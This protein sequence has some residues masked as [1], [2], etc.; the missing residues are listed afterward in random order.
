M[1]DQRPHQ[2]SDVRGPDFAACTP[3]QRESVL[4]GLAHRRSAVHAELLRAIAAADRAEDYKA[5]GMWSMADW[6]TYRYALPAPVARQWVKAAHALED[7]PLLRA[8][9]AA[10]NVSFDQ[11]TQALS[12]AKPDDD[13]TLAELLPTLGFAEVEAMAKRRRRLRRGDADDA[14]RQTHLR[15][16][17]DR[18][19]LGSRV[20]GFLPTEDAAVI[21]E[22]LDRRTEAAGPDPETGIWG[23]YDQ[24]TAHALRDLCAE[25]LADHAAPS[26]A[27]DASMVVIHVPASTVGWTGDDAPPHGNAT[28]NGDPIVSDALQ[29]RLCDTKIEFHVDSPT[30]A[31]VGIGRASRTIPLWLRRRILH[32]DGGCCRWPGCHRRIRHVHHIQHWTRDG[33]TDAAN[34]MGVCWHHH[35]LL[36]EGGWT[37]TGNADDDLTITSPYGRTIHSRAGPIAA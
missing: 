19:G 25:D 30:G 22:A 4:D 20:S 35:H 8:Q 23:P 7:L 31:T 36:H 2:P 26:T 27:P 9:Y 15:I 37:A 1:S 14:H 5:D 10:G 21:T 16:R 6:L 28:I 24:R 34:L 3:D 12:W 17:P 32:R 33:P 18:S 11:V 13:A 29:R